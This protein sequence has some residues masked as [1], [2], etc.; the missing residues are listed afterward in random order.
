[1]QLVNYDG[2]KLTLHLHPGQTAAHDSTKRFVFIIAGTQSGKTSYLPL[3][4]EQEIRNKGEGDYLAVTA[5]YDL[6][7]MK[8][9]PE[10]Q[11]YFCHILGWQES[12]SERTI[13][14][15]Y[16]PRMFTRIICRSADAEGGLESASAKAAL[17]DECGQGGVKVNAW[18]ALQRRLS[19][20]QGRVLAG[21]TPYNLGWLKTQIFDKW[22]GGDPDI[23]VVQFKS[24]MNPSF[25]VEEYE[26]ARRTLPAWKFEMFYNGNFSRPAGMIYEDF[27]QLH[28]IPSFDIPAGWARYLGVDFGAVHT[29]KIW[30][31][32][33]PNSKL[34]YLY[35]ESLEGG[36]TTA[37]HVAAVKQYNEHNLLA[38]GG[39]K[40]ETQQRMDW[41][42]AGLRLGEP[43]VADVEAGINRVIALFKESKLFIFSNCTGIIDELGTYSREMDASGQATE[44]IK[45]KATF[46]R[47]DALRYVVGGLQSSLTI[48]PTAS[49]GNYVNNSQAQIDRPRF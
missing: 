23:Q 2:T 39:A 48:N 29:S 33:D 47:L 5:T 44:K 28:I 10:L 46:H 18:E 34:Y 40:S 49:I 6:L 14:K 19:L 1:M 24:T 16:K 32:Q 26:R 21:T 37:E 42:A 7:K 12:K 15:E 8:F 30:I 22:R 4:L 31:A 27:S 45:D 13:Y 43:R 3:W 35:R 25:P 11:N 9:M 41:G 17:F 20:S 36:K 38:W